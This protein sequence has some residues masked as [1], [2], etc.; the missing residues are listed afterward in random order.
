VSAGDFHFDT[1]LVHAGEPRPRPEGAITQPIYQSSTYT[2]AGHGDYDSLRYLRLSNS[3]NHT[4][5]AEKIAAL[6]AAPAAL[7]TASGMGAISTALLSLVGEGEHLISQDILYGGTYHFL[8]QYFPKLG[9][10]VSFCG[11]HDLEALEKQI[12]PETKGIYI[13]SISNPLL[14]IP[15]LDGII[16]IAKRKGLL[17]FI[18][19]TFASPFNFQPIPYGFDVVLHSAT[20]YLNGH[21]DVSAGAIAGSEAHVGQAIR[22]QNTLGGILDPNSCFLLNRGLKTLGVRMRAHNQN[23]QG[24][25]ETLAEHRKVE[26]VYYPGLPSHPDHA[27]GKKLFRG[28]G[29]VLSF[30]FRGTP[31]DADE[32]LGRLRLP[33][34]APSLGGVETL[35]TRPVTTS[36]SI[37]PL[38]ERERLGIR[39]N[40]VR[41]ACGIEDTDDLRADFLQAL[42]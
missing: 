7:V 42:G 41:V 18:D 5:L 38:S 14:Q 12:R 24:L 20:K 28:F 25:A 15:D 11:M 27:R 32:F 21:S 37:L 8:H 23:A 9:R 39:E 2:Y 22:F 30:E 35:I 31:A 10:K 29:G 33:S 36:H 34:L 6:E 40:L 19:N 4:C 26:K 17:T 3:P 13:E 16:Q 1:L